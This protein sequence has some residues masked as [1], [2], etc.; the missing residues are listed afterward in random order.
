MCVCV[1]LFFLLFKFSAIC[2]LEM[3]FQ[4]YCVHHEILSF[5]LFPTL[6]FS[7]PLFHSAWQKMDSVSLNII[8]CRHRV[9]RHSFDCTLTLLK[10]IYMIAW[11]RKS[12]NTK[13]SERPQ[14]CVCLC[15]LYALSC[16]RNWI[17]VS[18]E[19]STT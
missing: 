13:L 10:F 8:I 12:C 14:L 5:S 19:N 11:S 16:R 9:C 2:V 15:L 17:S 7:L 18:M 3:K 6:S 1:C 4:N